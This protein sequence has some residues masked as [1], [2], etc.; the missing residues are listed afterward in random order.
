MGV[1]IDHVL[2]GNGLVATHAELGGP[3]GSDHRAIF[4]RMTLLP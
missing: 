2:L 1:K 3:T 4:A